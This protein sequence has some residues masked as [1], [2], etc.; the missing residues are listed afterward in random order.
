MSG[1][2]IGFAFELRYLLAPAIHN[3]FGEYQDLGGINFGVSMRAHTW[4]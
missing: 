1:R 2:D 3:E 4:E